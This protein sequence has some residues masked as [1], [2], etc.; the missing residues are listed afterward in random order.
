VNIAELEAAQAEAHAATH[1]ALVS[2][3]MNSTPLGRLNHGEVRAVL[4]RMAQLGY[5]VVNAGGHEK[6]LAALLALPGK[7]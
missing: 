1:S 3:L 6:A 2:D 5:A 4:H 7:R